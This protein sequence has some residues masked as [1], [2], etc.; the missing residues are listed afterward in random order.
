MLIIKH[1]LM[2]YESLNVRN[3]RIWQDYISALV[4]NPCLCLQPY[5]R[6]VHVNVH[7]F[8]QWMCRCGHTVAE[9]KSS[10]VRLKS[11]ESMN[12]YVIPHDHVF[13][14]VRTT[15]PRASS[16]QDLLHGICVTHPD[17]TVTTIRS[18]SAEAV[19]SFLRLYSEEVAPCSD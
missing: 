11:E 9:A 6:S 4:V 18:G 1:A 2:E 19:V 12:S 14:P 17:G 16:P 15:S 13:L 7:A 5:L 3:E 10:I 8:Q